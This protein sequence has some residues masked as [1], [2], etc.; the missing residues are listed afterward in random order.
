MLP[1]CF[2]E[3]FENAPIIRVVLCTIISLGFLFV[4]NVWQCNSFWKYVVPTDDGVSMC[5]TCFLVPIL[6]DVIYV[7]THLNWG[8]PV[9]HASI[10]LQVS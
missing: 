2:D 10:A 7:I 3:F 1:C 8:F 9:Y 5:S 6:L 4:V